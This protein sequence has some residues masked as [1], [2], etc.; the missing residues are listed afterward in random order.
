MLSCKSIKI[1]KTA[2]EAPPKE[3]IDE[4]LKTQDSIAELN[5][6][7]KPYYDSTDCSFHFSY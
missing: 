3:F 2:C 5:H 4:Y 6:W 7:Q 1:T